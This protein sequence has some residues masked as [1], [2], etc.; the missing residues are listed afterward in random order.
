LAEVLG[1]NSTAALNFQDADTA[2]ELLGSLRRQPAVSFACIYDAAGR[3][4]AI[5]S[6]QGYDANFQPPPA[7][8]QSG[9]QFVERG[10]LDVT[11]RIDHDG[12]PIGTIYLHANV[13]EL[14]NQI[15]RYALI[16]AGVMIISLGSSILL[17]AR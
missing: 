12:Q 2:R 6:Q 5:Y 10:Y 14:H 1:A 11:Q 16:V 3:P 17:S 15:V 8:D 9:Y 13:D 4:F 7:S